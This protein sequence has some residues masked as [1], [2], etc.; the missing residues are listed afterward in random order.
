MPDAQP[1]QAEQQEEGGVRKWMGIA[2]VCR[3]YRPLH[4]P[5]ILQNALLIWGLIQFGKTFFCL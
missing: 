2:Q 4:A 1:A 3:M 5:D